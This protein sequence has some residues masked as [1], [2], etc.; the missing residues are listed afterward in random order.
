[1]VLAMFVANGI[2]DVRV[3][4]VAYRLVEKEAARDKL[5]DPTFFPQGVASQAFIPTVRDGLPKVARTIFE[6]RYVLTALPLLLILY[7]MWTRPCVTNAQ[8]GLAIVLGAFAMAAKIHCWEM[9]CWLTDFY[10]PI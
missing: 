9:L 6:G 8:L 7:F 2:F 5:G 4:H 1:M 3:A 10:M